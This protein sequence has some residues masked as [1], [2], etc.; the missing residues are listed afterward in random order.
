MTLQL[1]NTV[2][3]WQQLLTYYSNCLE[4]EHRLQYVIARDHVSK[5]CFFAPGLS[6]DF[7]RQKQLTCA[8]G[9]PRNQSEQIERLR[10]FV[11]GDPGGGRR[12][13]TCLGYPFYV[14]R[15]QQLIPLIYVQVSGEQDDAGV[16]LTRESADLEVNYAAIW[17][18]LPGDKSVAFDDLMTRFEEVSNEAGNRAFERLLALLVAQVEEVSGVPLQRMDA[19]GYRPGS[20]PRNTIV[21]YPLL[22]H[23][24]NLITGQ[25]LRELEQLRRRTWEDAQPALHQ[26]LTR[27]V[28]APYPEPPEPGQ[29]PRLYVA[30]ANERQRQAITSAEQR[31]LT[32]VTGPPGTGK[33]QLIVNIV[34]N[35]ILRGES[36][37]IASR[38]NQAV[39][40]ISERFLSQI[41]YPGAVR[42][43]KTQY[44]RL[45]PG[46]MQETLARLRRGGVT[47]QLAEMRSHHEELLCRIREKSAEIERIRSLEADRKAYDDELH[48]LLGLLPE[49]AR[50]SF[51]KA[52]VRFEEGE[53]PRLAAAVRGLVEQVDALV[54]REAALAGEAKAVLAQDRDGLALLDQ[55]RVVEKQVGVS[56]DELRYG[57]SADDLAGIDRYLTGWESLL[58]HLTAQEEA[59]RGAKAVAV[60][61]RRVQDCAENLRDDWSPETDRFVEL[62][63]AESAAAMR[64]ALEALKEQAE[65][66]SAPYGEF[67]ER[68][69]AVMKGSPAFSRALAILQ[70][71][72]RDAGSAKATADLA[73]CGEMFRLQAP[74]L[75]THEGVLDKARAHKQLDA[76]E[77][78]RSAKLREF[79]AM[80]GQLEGQ[81][82][83]ARGQVPAI[84]VAKVEAS[85]DRAYWKSWSEA[86]ERL[87]PVAGWCSRLERG[88]LTLKERLRRIISRS[89]AVN[90]LRGMLG[91]LLPSLES[92]GLHEVRDAPAD[93]DPFEAWAGF[94]RDLAQFSAAV[95]LLGQKRHG[96]EQRDAY[97]QQIERD[98]AEQAAEL[99]GA[100]ARLRDMAAALPDRLAQAMTGAD[101]PLVAV[102]TDMVEA[103]DVCRPQYEALAAGVAAIVRDLSILMAER[104]A[105]GPVRAFQSSGLLGTNTQ[106]TTATPGDLVRFLSSWLKFSLTVEAKRELQRAEGELEATQ[107]RM[108]R[109]RAKLPGPIR[110]VGFEAVECSADTAA[111]AEAAISALRSDLTALMTARDGLQEQ[112]CRLLLQNCLGTRALQ[113]ALLHA[114]K[115][116]DY[117][118]GLL[119][120]V[121][122]T[123]LTELARFL[124]GWLVVFQAWEVTSLLAQTSRELGRFPTFDEA[125]SQ[126]QGLLDERQ[127]LAS[128]VLAEQWRQVAL[129]LG[130]DDRTA[131]G[132]G[133][134]AMQALTQNVGPQFSSLKRQ[135]DN[136]FVQI[137]KLFPV[138][139][140]TNL[141][142]QDLPLE[143][144]LFDCVIIDEAS[145]C[146]IPSALPLLFRAKRAVII[147]DQMQL[148]HIASLPAPLNGQLCARYAVGSRFSFI[149]K[150]LFDLAASSVEGEPG[151]ILLRDHYRSHREIIKF[152][153]DSFYDGQLS[154]LTDLDRV[155]P[156]YQTRACGVY[157]LDVQGAAKRPGAGEVYNAA[158]VEAV[159]ALITGLVPQL[160]RLGMPQASIG[161]VTPFRAQKERIETALGQRGM[162]PGQVQVGTIHTYQGD[163]RDIMVFSPVATKELPERT[164]GFIA[165]DRN[166]LNVAITR[167]KLTLFVVG[168]HGFFWHLA[169]APDYRRLAQYTAGMRRVYPTMGELPVFEPVQEEE[170]GWDLGHGIALRPGTPYANRMTLRRLLASCESFVWWYDP[171][172]NLDALD[173]L[174]LALPTTGGRIQEVR[175]LTS[176][177]YWE[178]KGVAGAFTRKH[179]AALERELERNG[180]RLRLALTAYDPDHPPAHDRYLFA[181]NRSVNM[182]PIK[183]IYQEA[184]RLAEFLPSTVRPEEFEEWWHRAKV[185]FD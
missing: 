112:C 103:L 30:P 5:T 136:S 22:F 41:D 40:T 45:L 165:R 55:L 74:F 50:G 122:T 64:G 120:A 173:A 10:R 25:V 21:D 128:Q 78:E 156:M 95:S 133:V 53:Y 89:W 44:R 175:L 2:E 94:A 83:A 16:T 60:A 155:P 20:L 181:A 87:A 96:L 48:D 29:D 150:S 137:L 178:K 152:A 57:R 23:V 51:G 131:I 72:D 149:D 52:Q 118:P 153:S 77:R 90:H 70:T 54:Q 13:S 12:P 135:V 32:V 97:R 65:A 145:Q 80:L 56:L 116:P 27:S 185:V 142:T 36:V 91:A 111:Q 177:E 125:Q 42:T 19:K 121:P 182:P 168:D 31:S 9:Y 28:R 79:D 130:P 82:S 174:S 71:R 179:M 67:Q 144:G 26:L 127:S 76:L 148:R 110:E 99:N 84:L 62:L 183:N 109:A 63:D 160:A 3:G 86:S 43:G 18:A 38:N 139:S 102:P 47:S 154:I 157:W 115:N 113:Q 158:E 98:M 85:A 101:W 105:P 93:M 68:I 34:G 151:Q 17:D 123:S 69:S 75:A 4:Q 108:N 143:P 24:T 106:P 147:G 166:L 33:S 170:R 164:L 132:D 49:G 107:A 7:I 119:N 184:A 171:Y 1:V 88:E 8:I 39:D 104:A 126:R 73:A 81:L 117:L 163:E 167:A 15:D 141:S 35:A 176:E 114:Q 92:L 162:R 46:Q 138:W 180:T 59:D 66:L 124:R 14:G 169:A 134:D 37:L 58:A 11:L 61:R 6:G 140:T 161:V 146:D 159:A 172:M 129:E 100:D